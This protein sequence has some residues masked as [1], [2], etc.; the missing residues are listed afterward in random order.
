M[1]R[2]QVITKVVPLRF[3]NSTTTSSNITVSFRVKEIK[4]KSLVYKDDTDPVL[5]ANITYGILSSSL[6]KNQ[7]IGIFMTDYRYS[8]DTNQG[9]ITYKFQQ[10]VTIEGSHTFYFELITGQ[11]LTGSMLL[12][13]EFHE[14][15]QT[16][17][18]NF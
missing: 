4:T 15:E 18:N 5:P 6:V 16:A 12:I 3:N 9:D 13:L 11:P 2:P 7:P 1:N 10:P 17:L 8:T 14:A